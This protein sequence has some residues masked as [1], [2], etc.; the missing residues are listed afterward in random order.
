M[1]EPDTALAVAS[2]QRSGRRSSSPRAPLPELALRRFADDVALTLRLFVPLPEQRQLRGDPQSLALAVAFLLTVT[3]A[4]HFAETSHRYEAIAFSPWGAYA[5][6][7]GL[8]ATAA[9]LFLLALANGVFG[10]LTA[11]LTGAAIVQTVGVAVDALVDDV[12]TDAAMAWRCLCMV[13]T[14]RLV[15]REVETASAHRWLTGVAVV[16]LL[17]AIAEALPRQR[18]FRPVFPAAP[19]PLDIERIYLDQPR[20][21]EEA[22]AAVPLS[23]PDVPET[24]FVGFASYSAQDVF[25]N[26]VRHAQALFRDQLGAAERTLLLVNSRDTMD[27]LPLANR[28]NLTRVLD[29]LAAKMDA[30]DLLFLHLTSHGS[31][32]HELDVAF[33][34]LGLNDLSAEQLG[35]AVNSANLP[36]SVVV[37]AACYSGGFIEPLQS[38]RTL[39]MTASSAD[40]VSFGCEHGREYTY[41]GEALYSDN[42]ANADYV[43]AFEHAR[44]IVEE[45]EA[46]E[47][48]TASEPQIW[49]GEAMAARLSAPASKSTDTSI[50]VPSSEQ[51]TPS[52]RAAL[53][54]GAMPLPATPATAARERTS[55]GEHVP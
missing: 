34:N 23:Q 54:E 15:V 55:S 46:Q 25:L 36:W 19:E 47:D 20:L 50:D 11:M 29:A 30:E 41:F 7:T 16:A 17:W 4:T 51:S 14:A 31:R 9:A 32:D 6:V 18:V 2:G 10:R 44:A 8:A 5:A 28:H 27:E 38:P 13:V 3:V 35:H 12:D 1:D 42:L 48:L 43:G 26:E 33:E 21:V 53:G 45:R 49:I 22:L 52:P 24:Y 40:E 39:V 37:V